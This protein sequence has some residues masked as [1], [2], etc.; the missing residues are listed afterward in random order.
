MRHPAVVNE[1]GDRAEEAGDEI[2]VRRGAGE[3]TGGDAPR[4]GA[5]RR[6]V[7]QR[8]ARQQRARERVRQRVN[9]LGL[10]QPGLRILHAGEIPHHRSS[11]SRP[12]N[13]TCRNSASAPIAYFMPRVFFAARP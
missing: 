8:G 11:F 7:R 2:E 12:E 4:D 9:R 10:A 3:E 6:A 5:R 1:V 13:V